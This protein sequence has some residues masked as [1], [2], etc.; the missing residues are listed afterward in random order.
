MPGITGVIGTDIDK[1]VSAFKKAVERRM[2]GKHRF[3]V[4]LSGGLD[5]R[6]VLGAIDKRYSPVHTFTYGVPGCDE[7]K[8]PYDKTGIRAD[9]PII[10]NK[11]SIF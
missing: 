11:F 5:S 1:L 4:S 8:I 10:L 6:T 9:A 3:G 7:A 2:I